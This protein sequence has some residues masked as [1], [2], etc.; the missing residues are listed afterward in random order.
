MFILKNSYLQ[1]THSFTITLWKVSWKNFYMYHKTRVI[2]FW[3][4]LCI[5][6][7]IVIKVKR[8]KKRSSGNLLYVFKLLC[9]EI[10]DI[11]SEMKI[12]LIL[13]LWIKGNDSMQNIHIFKT[14]ITFYIVGQHGIIKNSGVH[15]EIAIP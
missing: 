14:E 6:I 8:K 1:W 15:Q 10:I 7:K 9:L 12:L 3:Y 11:V 13:F 4:K 2:R 5:I